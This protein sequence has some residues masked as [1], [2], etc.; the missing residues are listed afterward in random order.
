MESLRTNQ[1][2]KKLT[3]LRKCA[4]PDCTC[5]VAEEEEYCSDYCMENMRADST[6]DE[7]GCGC[8]HAECISTVA[9]A[10]VAPFTS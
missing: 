3:S 9:L 5:T 8:G 10:P 7:E 6:I 1:G 4:H 2:S